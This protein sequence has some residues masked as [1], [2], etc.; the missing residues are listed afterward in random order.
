[1]KT[2]V[3]YDSAFGNTRQIAQAIGNALGSANEVEVH[4]VNEVQPEQLAG[5]EL[6]VVG[7]PTQKFRPLPT[8]TNL[9]QRIPPNSLNGVKVAAFDTRIS[10]KETKSAILNFFVKLSGPAAYAAKHIADGLKKSGGE[11]IVPPEGFLVDGTKGPLKPGE[12]ERAADW[13]KQAVQSNAKR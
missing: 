12:L 7:S 8:M 1:M 5:L 9:L 4:Q 13:I 2:F 3:I 6:L 10:V 11:L